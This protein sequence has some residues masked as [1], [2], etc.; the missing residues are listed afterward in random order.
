MAGQNKKFRDW[1]KIAIILLFLTEFYK[2]PYL[3]FRGN[4]FGE[5]HPHT[6]TDGQM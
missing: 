1:C 6:R 3:K 2:T 5:S 4:H